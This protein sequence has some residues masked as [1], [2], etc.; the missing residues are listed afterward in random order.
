MLS[1]RTIVVTIPLNTYRDVE[2]VPSLAPHKRSLIEEGQLSAGAKLYVH[3]KQNL[4]RVF[5]FCDEEQPL[6]W[7]QTHDYGDELGTL[8]SI[9]VAR[10]ELIDV[11]D[12]ET[13]SRETRRLFPG[14]DV[15]GSVAYDWQN[16]PYSKGAWPAYRVG[17]FGRIG[18]FREREGRL[19]FAGGATAD[20]WHEH[21]DG[22][23][24]SGLRAGR[25][26]RELL[27]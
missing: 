23:V 27:G 14:V 26:V 2:F 3:V 13:V 9:T 21:I 19:I 16:D 24:E 22:A 15:I 17:Q 7:V 10:R 6:N 8:L 5:G 1:A 20:G 11:A 25:E 18:K 4:G 12:Q